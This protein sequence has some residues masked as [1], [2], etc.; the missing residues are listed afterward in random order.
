MK[1]R[2]FFFPFSELHH[3]FH[4]VFCFCFVFC[5][6]FSFFGEKESVQVVGGAGGE[7]TRGNLKQTLCSQQNA[8]GVRSQ[9][10][11]I[12][13]GWATKSGRL[14]PLSHPDAKDSHLVF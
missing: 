13:N 10:L 12:M 3:D 7:R 2:L 5:V 8:T 9:F 14:N 11:E 4:L 6:L 1:D